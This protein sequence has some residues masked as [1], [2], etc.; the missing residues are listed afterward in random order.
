M[1]GRP[2]PSHGGHRMLLEKVRF[3]PGGGEVWGG[4]QEDIL[5]AGVFLGRRRVG[6]VQFTPDWWAGMAEQAF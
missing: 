1:A 3:A 4:W 6:R 5:E 2:V